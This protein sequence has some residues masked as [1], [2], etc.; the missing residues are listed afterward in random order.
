VSARFTSRLAPLLAMACAA[1]A[2]PAVGA[3]LCRDRFV[4]SARATCPVDGTTWQLELASSGAAT[5]FET[6]VDDGSFHSVRL[7]GTRLRE[8]AW[9]LVAREDTGTT[10]TAGLAGELV[11]AC[12][13]DGES[14]HCAG[15]DAEAAWEIRFDRAPL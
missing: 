6:S 9:S 14:L 12:A 2:D 8:G 1:P 7:E 3:W 5:L 10:D 15:T 11:L 4:E 13:R